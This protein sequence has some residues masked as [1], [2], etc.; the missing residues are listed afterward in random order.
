MTASSIMPATVTSLPAGSHVPSAAASPT[1]VSGANSSLNENDFLQLLTT[2]LEHQDPLNPVSPSDFAAELAQFATAT[3]VQNLNTTFNASSGLQAA[4]L[5]G[6]NVAVAGN[7]LLLGA[8]NTA[9]G[10]FSL[11]GAATDVKVA[12]TDAAGA[13]VGFLD[14]G[15]MAA[16]TQ[17]FAWNGQTIAGGAAP[18]GAYSYTISATGKNGAALSATPFSVVPVTAVSLGGTGGPRLSLGGGMAP[19]AL[20]A[21]QQVF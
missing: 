21:V 13:V 20:S 8:G 3:G 12:I 5:V 16:G 14:L 1:G 6:R 18:Q 9:S 10:A 2:Q 11:P 19:V 15:P 7:T 17:S 4:A